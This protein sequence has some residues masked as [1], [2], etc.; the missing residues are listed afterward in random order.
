MHAAEVEM[1]Q[2]KT[3]SVFG[4][5]TQ[6]SGLVHKDHWPAAKREGDHYQMYVCVR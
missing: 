1:L 4:S 3:R 6:D 2:A 5:G